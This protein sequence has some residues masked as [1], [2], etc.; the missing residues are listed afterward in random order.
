VH[1]GDGTAEIFADDASVFTCSLHGRGNFP[2]RKE[3]SDLDV[4]LADGTAD[5]AYLATLRTALPRAVERSRPD[6]VIYLAG[7][8]PF[9][10]DRLGRLAL[11]KPG[12]AARDRYVLET[13][14][15]AAIPVAI[16][17][18]GGYAENIDDV[19]DIHFA[20]VAIGL[21]LFAATQP[22]FARARHA[23]C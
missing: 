6:L 15:E 17:M 5:N 18:A 21:E 8:D 9:V 4:E 7:A 16:A 23:A 12:L 10:G 11:T 1:Q 22:I 19:A 13:L 3:A 14:R 20:T 2:F